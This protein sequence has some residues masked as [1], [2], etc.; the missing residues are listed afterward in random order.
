MNLWSCWPCV[1][2][3]AK[4][5]IARDSYNLFTYGVHILIS[6][7]VIIFEK[8]LHL[9]RL[10]MNFILILIFGVIFVCHKC[11]SR[12]LSLSFVRAIFLCLFHWHA[13]LI[14]FCFI[15]AR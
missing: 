2:E 3:I 10:I 13:L 12:I 5:S 6:L 14:T 4:N 15:D 1:I 7:C 8:R 11:L 9:H